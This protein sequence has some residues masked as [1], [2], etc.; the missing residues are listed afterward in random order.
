MGAGGP[1]YWVVPRAS[2]HPFAWVFNDYTLTATWLLVGTMTRYRWLLV[3]DELIDMSI[4]FCFVFDVRLNWYCGVHVRCSEKYQYKVVLILQVYDFSFYL[5]YWLD[6]FNKKN[7]IT[8]KS[9]FCLVSRLFIITSYDSNTI[10]YVRIDILY[11][12]WHKNNNKKEK[13]FSWIY[14]YW[15]FC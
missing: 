1:G 2:S 8:I 7:L 3:I 4:V 15:T 9:P 5:K 14:L 11:L 6:K 13:L 12:F 10:F